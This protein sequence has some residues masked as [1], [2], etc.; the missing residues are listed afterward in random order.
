MDRF[1]RTGGWLRR[2]VAVVPVAARPLVLQ[3]DEH[4]SEEHD[5][6]AGEMRFTEAGEMRLRNVDNQ[7]LA[8]TM[9]KPGAVRNGCLHHLQASEV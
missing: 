3:H 5:A 1:L 8:N 7:K 4:D 2:Q 6:E 9:Q